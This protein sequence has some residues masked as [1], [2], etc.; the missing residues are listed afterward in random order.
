MLKVIEKEKEGTQLSEGKYSGR[1]IFSRIERVPKCREFLMTVKDAHDHDRGKR[2][3]E[4]ISLY[5]D[6]NQSFSVV[7]WAKAISDA[8][9]HGWL[10]SVSR[11]IGSGCVIRICSIVAEHLLQIMNHEFEAALHCKLPAHGAGNTSQDAV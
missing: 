4:D 11:G 8:F 3:I 9:T 10:V 1:L 7:D 5:L 6:G 2:M